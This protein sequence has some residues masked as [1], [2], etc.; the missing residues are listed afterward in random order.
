MGR[1]AWLI[2]AHNEF[3]I[4]QMLISA[5]D[6]AR[7]DIFIHIDKKVTDLPE[8]LTQKSRLFI[9]QERLDVR[10][11][12]PSQIRCEMLLLQTAFEKGEYSRFHLISGT[13]L[14]LKAIN[15]IYS[16]FSEFETNGELM[17]LWEKDE[18]DIGN[19]FQRYNLFVDGFS[20]KLAWIRR[21]SHFGWNLSQ[22]VQKR[23]G[24]RRFPNEV[25]IKS[26]N[27]VSLSRS[28][29]NYLLEHADDIE[30]K[31]RYSYCGDE[32]FVATELNKSGTF[33][34]I[35]TDKLL[36]TDFIRYN[37]K[38]YTMDDYTSLISSECLFARKFSS[39]HLDIARQI[40]KHSQQ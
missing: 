40:I 21:L 6:D 16:F 13:H 3:E 2:I 11:G 17:H 24:V 30:K 22:S 31:Y 23:L 5:L 7:G 32:Y 18:R 38:I 1:H 20:S 29:V 4:L 26:D 15:E 27:W 34:I 14:P 33:L 10:W 39:V 8:I 19:K 12:A 36:K 28:A 35:D 9:L 37:P 25:F